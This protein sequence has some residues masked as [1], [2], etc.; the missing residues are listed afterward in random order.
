MQD[1]L[2]VV[3]ALEYIVLVLLAFLYYDNW[4]ALGGAAFL[5]PYFLFMLHLIPNLKSVYIEKYVTNKKLPA[6]KV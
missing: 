6:G 3:I 4:V 2:F 1:F 5:L